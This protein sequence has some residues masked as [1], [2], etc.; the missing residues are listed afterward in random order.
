MTLARQKAEN[1]EIVDAICFYTKAQHLSLYIGEGLKA[2]IFNE[3]EDLKNWHA[4]DE[5]IEK[6]KRNRKH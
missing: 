2:T 6:L 3:N 1:N 4:I 5:I